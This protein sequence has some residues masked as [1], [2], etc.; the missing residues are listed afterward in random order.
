MTKYNIEGNIDFFSE[1]YKSFDNEEK[2]DENNNLCLITDEPLKD[3]FIKLECNHTF[4]YIPLYLDIK[5]HKQKF[6]FMEGNSSKLNNNEI[7]C[8]YCRKKHSGLL[9]FYEE[10]ALPKVHGVNFIDPNFKSSTSQK[11]PFISCQ[12]LTPN[13]NYDPS[14]NNP[15]EF[16]LYNFGNCKFHK[17]FKAGTPFILYNNSENEEIIDDKNYCWQHKKEIVKNKEKLKQK[18]EKLKQKEEK[19]KQKEEKLKQKEEKLKQKEE[20]QKNKKDKKQKIVSENVVLGPSIITDMSG[21][22]I[23][24]GCVEILKSGPNKGNSCGSKIVSENMCKRHYM[25]NH[26]ELILHTK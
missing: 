9:P 15:E 18:E 21:N 20:K 13:V 24:L 23:F 17:C 7:R 2:N 12:F 11:T 1:L 8:P 26:K 10:L 6:N 5:N 19:L 25:L 4:N 22:E 14:G 3:K 16:N